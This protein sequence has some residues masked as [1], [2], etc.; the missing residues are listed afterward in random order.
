MNFHKGPKNPSRSL[1]AQPN[2]EICIFDK[3]LHFLCK[4]QFKHRF[5]TQ[6]LEELS[7]DLIFHY[8][9]WWTI[10]SFSQQN[11]K[12][13]IHSELDRNQSKLTVWQCAKFFFFQTIVIA[14]LHCLISVWFYFSGIMHICLHMSIFASSNSKLPPFN[15]N[16]Q[17][18]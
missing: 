18:K 13:R 12:L 1:F 11:S 10:K 8:H 17:N 4:K 5:K 14:T 3:N 15:P 7:I 2:L 6:N 16:H 9:F